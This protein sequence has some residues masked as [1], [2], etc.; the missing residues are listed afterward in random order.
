[1][2]P[3]GRFDVTALSPLQCA[4]YRRAVAE[5][6]VLA[7]IRARR[8]P[9]QQND[10]VSAAKRKDL[11]SLTER[12]RRRLSVEAHREL[13]FRRPLVRLGGGAFSEVYR[14]EVANPPTGM[15]AKLVL[16]LIPHGG[17]D[18]RREAAIQ[19]GAR[20]G[21][22]PAPCVFI[23]ESDAAVLGAPF[24]VMEQMP[25]RGFLGGIEWYRFAADFPKVVARWPSA[26]DLTMDTLAK[27]DVAEV[28]SALPRYGLGRDDVL[29][30]RH[31]ATVE[32]R[33]EGDL[34]MLPLAE[35]IKANLPPQP[36]SPSLVHGD[37][38]PANVLFRG[39]SISGLVDWSRAGLGDPAADIGFAR[40]GLALMPEPF[41][42]PPPLS[43]MIRLAGRDL[44]RRITSKS[45]DSTDLPVRIRYYE[46]L[47][48]ALELVDAKNA[49]D[50]GVG[51]GWAHGVPALCR[52]VDRL[53]GIKPE[54]RLE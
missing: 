39:G 46:V 50:R 34:G 18:A 22:V 9:W 48:S 14:F 15:P 28:I 33:A 38:W 30:E 23:T 10:V 41:P 16:R 51:G 5:S 4:D 24:V 13:T 43:S 36:E 32:T 52:H 19:E 12:L 11:S 29:F 7:Y 31:V 54:V 17:L 27:A 49:S 20:A 35:W 3:S 6:K 53:I 40:V 21:G 37:L 45:I 8:L 2:V 25:G 42:P 44:A 1:M 47:R 26:F